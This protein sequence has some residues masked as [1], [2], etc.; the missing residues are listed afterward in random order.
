MSQ[1]LCVSQNRPY[2]P[3]A[4]MFIKD[5]LSPT[6]S[7]IAKPRLGLVVPLRVKGAVHWT[8]HKAAEQSPVLTKLGLRD[9][10]QGGLDPLPGAVG[11]NC[12]KLSQHWAQ[13]P[14]GS[15]GT[16]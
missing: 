4:A 15:V 6:L 5:L 9:R 11:W 14:P 13:S 16:A 2:R 8:P 10:E 12:H 3:A 7:A 1:V